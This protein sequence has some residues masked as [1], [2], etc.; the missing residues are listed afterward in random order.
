MS[1]EQRSRW[2]EYMDTAAA[3][4]YTGFSPRTL[5]KLRWSGGGPAYYRLAGIRYLREDLDSWL[6][7]R[8]RLTGVPQLTPR[9]GR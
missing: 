7:S 4:R 2:R 5:E 8:R 9:I 6:E 1:D 3:G